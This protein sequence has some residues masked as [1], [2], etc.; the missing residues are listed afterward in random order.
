M[1]LLQATADDG[2]PDSNAQPGAHAAPT[3]FGDTGLE[4]DGSGKFFPTVQKKSLCP[5]EGV[6]PGGTANNR[7]DLCLRW[8][9]SARALEGL[10]C[11]GTG[12][13]RPPLPP[14]GRREC[15]ASLFSQP[16]MSLILPSPVKTVPFLWGWGGAL[17]SITCQL[18]GFGVVP[19]GR[20]PVSPSVKWAQWE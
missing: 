19:S 14:R 9:W 4:G 16:G 13:N 18:G 17:C 7:R 5:M 12:E 1:S 15:V 20:V 2:A 11:D 10:G 6:C 8:F 3:L